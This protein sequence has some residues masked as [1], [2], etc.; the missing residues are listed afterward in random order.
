VFFH[1]ICSYELEVRTK[2]SRKIQ[3]ISSYEFEGNQ[4]TVNLKDQVERTIK[5]TDGMEEHNENSSFEA[6]KDQLIH[7]NHFLN[8]PPE[9]VIVC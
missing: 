5:A 2:L 4:V 3:K 1:S 9:F 7:Y 8:F 6:S